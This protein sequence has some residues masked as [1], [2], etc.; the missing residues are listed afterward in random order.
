MAFAIFYSY[1][2]SAA[3]TEAALILICRLCKNYM[4]T[5]EVSNSEDLV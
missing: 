5:D 1:V 4:N 3:A 2:Y